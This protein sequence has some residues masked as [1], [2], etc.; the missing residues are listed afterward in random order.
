[1]PDPDWHLLAT[2]PDAMSAES[3]ATYLRAAGI[4]VQLPDGNLATLA[5][6]LSSAI[7]GVRLLV[8]GADLERAETFLD[9]LDADERV[10]A[11]NHIRRP[12]L[13]RSPPAPGPSARKPTTPAS[14]TPPDRHVKRSFVPEFA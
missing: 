2:F 11:A 7:G 9:A 12:L 5:W 14:L 10:G 13:R 4:A 6:H 8:K 1:M 3:T